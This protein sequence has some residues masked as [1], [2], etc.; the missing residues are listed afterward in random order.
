[1]VAIPPTIRCVVVMD[2]LSR[3]IPIVNKK[4]IANRLLTKLDIDRIVALSFDFKCWFV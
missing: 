1:M 4:I 3:I 2:V